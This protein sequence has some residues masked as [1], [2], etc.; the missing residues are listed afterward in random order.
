MPFL[1]SLYSFYSDPVPRYPTCCFKP[2]TDWKFVAKF[3]KL[4][5]LIKQKQKLTE[6]GWL[7]SRHD[8]K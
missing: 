8:I 5:R 2:T 6:I 1:D 3:S 7:E 4:L